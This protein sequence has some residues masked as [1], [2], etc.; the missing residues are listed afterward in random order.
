MKSNQKTKPIILLILGIFFAFAPLFINNL[1]FTAKDHHITL[2]YYD[3]F[4]HDNIKISAVSTPIHI[5]DANPTMN[6]SVAKKD[7]ICTGNGTY[8][9]PY[10]IEDLVID[11]GGSGNCIWIEN[12][13]VFFRIENCTLYNAGIFGAGIELYRVDNS[14]LVE[15]NCSFNRRGIHLT[16]GNNHTISGNTVNNNTREGIYLTVSI[17]SSVNNTISGNTANNNPSGI[18]LSSSNYNNITGNFVNNN[19]VGIWVE[20][21]YKINVL[22]NI[23]NNNDLG[24]ML[25]DANHTVSGNIMNECGLGVSSASS[26]EELCSYNIDTTNLV[27]G[28]PLYYE[29]D[30]T[31]L[32]SSDFTNAGQVILVNCTDSIISNLDFSF[33]SNGI[34]I[35]YCSGITILGNNGFNQIIG[36]MLFYSYNNTISEN[37]ESSN[38]N[39]GIYIA[40]G[41]N[42]TVIGNT[43]NYN[44]DYGIYLSSSNNNTLSGNIA[45]SNNNDGISLDRSDYNTISGNTVNSNEIGIRLDESNNNTV[46]QNMIKGNNGGL[47]IEALPGLFDS[48]ENSIFLNCFIDNNNNAY[49]EG[50]NNY[51]DNG[52]KGNYW[53]DYTGSDAGGDGIGDVPY[54]ITGPAGSQDNFPLMMC[55]IS[56]QKG[57]IPIELNILIS[58][59]S[60]GA[61][62][63]VA[64]FLLIRRKRKRIE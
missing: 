19:N 7:G 60:G 17:Y 40:V 44:N 29:C 34:A 12:S 37:I 10:V 36:I 14:Q 9:E 51:W 16:D 15:N 24:I 2:N 11:G 43:A 27:N 20:D 3:E 30:E 55:P 52:I 22:G 25:S 28:K 59:I 13:N 1:R 35:Y 45:N 54:N 53:S 8:S 5:N 41:D 61:V 42:N 38:E 58:V 57:G 47:W 63:G 23:V 46:T 4:D 50:T 18:H 32:G 26:I 62:I 56:T 64:T 31:H 39:Y 33:C 21:C 6:W 48:S 49:D